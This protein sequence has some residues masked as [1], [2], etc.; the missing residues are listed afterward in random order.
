[1]YDSEGMDC[2]QCRDV[3][4]ASLDGEATADEQAGADAHLLGCDACRRYAASADRVTRLSRV[5]PAGDVPDVVTPLLASLGIVEPDPPEP[6][7]P[8]V[9]ELTCHSGGCCA[10]PQPEAAAAPRSA[11]GCPAT[12]GCGCQQGSACR[13]STRAA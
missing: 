9:P 13:C 1:M 4:S 3:V 12:C 2:Q 10:T 7:A 11:C 8:A 6:V 5:R